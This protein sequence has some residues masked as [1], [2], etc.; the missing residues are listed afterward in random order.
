MY[1][2][3][4]AHIWAKLH[5]KVRNIN[6]ID[7]F[8]CLPG[9]PNYLRACVEVRFFLTRCTVY[10][11]Y[12]QVYIRIVRLLLRPN[13]SIMVVSGYQVVVDLIIYDSSSF[14]SKILYI[15]RIFLFI[16]V[17]GGV[18]TG[19]WNGCCFITTANYG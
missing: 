14:I 1:S 6:Q 16:Y 7:K 9:G 4:N 11:L 18:H 13:S 5:F 12:R 2:W 3:H 19:D 8:W 15:L 10:C 17:S